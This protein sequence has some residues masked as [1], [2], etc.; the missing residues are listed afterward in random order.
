MET[1]YIFITGGVASSLGKGII[2]AS[3]GKLLQ[4]RGFKITIQ[5]FDPYINIDP[6]TLN[7]YEHGECYVT[8]DGQETDLDLGHYERFTGIQTTRDNSV[9]TG[10]I[11]LSVIERE[12]RGDYLGKT[13]QVV[14][15]ITDEIKRRIRLNATKEHFDFVITEIGGTIGDIESQPFLEAIRQLRWELGHDAL[16]IHL[17]YVPYLAAAGELKTKPTQTSVKQLQGLG[18]QPEVLVLRTEHTLSDELRAKVAHFCNV[19]VN[20]VIQSQDLPS[21]YEVPANMQRQGLDTICLKKMEIEAEGVADLG[22]WHDFLERR[23]N[24]TKVLNIGLVG[25]YDLQDAYKS[26]IESLAHAGTY[27]DH[28]V[29]TH[30]INSEHIKADNVEELL[31]PMA[32][33]VICPGFGSRGIEGKILAAQYART[34]NLPAFGICLGMQMM[35]IEFARNVLGYADANSSEIDVKTPH[36][37]IDIME[38]QKSI[39]RKGGTMRLGAYA[40][41]LK[42]GS[43]TFNAYGGKSLIMERHRHRYE[44]NNRFRDEYESAGM[45]CVGINP[46][47]K[48]V[49]IVELPSHPWYIG[50]Q[51]HPEYSSTVLQPHPLF[52]DFIKHCI[53]GATEA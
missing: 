40:C 53:N 8:A 45:H 18:I 3:L 20:A 16:N 23:N 49:E 52:M 13:I 50:T 34:H 38:E 7:P 27:N 29:H 48:L 19:D 51:F 24:A 41:R 26:I 14:P 22:A 43:H 11:Y 37:V 2:S 39:T 5:K 25:K 1:K 47:S 33:I 4:A 44:F 15:H 6:G 10:R 17:T 28:K 12:R 35:V 9:T 21:I 32:G 42:E 30:F 31:S 36:N 46:T